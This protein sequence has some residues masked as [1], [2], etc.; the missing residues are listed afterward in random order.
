MLNIDLEEAH[1]T[2]EAEAVI[3]PKEWHCVTA[4]ITNS[5]S[6]GRSTLTVRGEVRQALHCLLHDRGSVAVVRCLDTS[7]SA[8]GRAG[9]SVRSFRARRL[10]ASKLQRWFGLGQPIVGAIALAHGG[11]S[12]SEYGLTGRLRS[13]YGSMLMFGA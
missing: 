1:L 6:L 4:G 3:S 13:N 7:W 8:D 11:E 12:L 5:G 9:W 2:V 10:L